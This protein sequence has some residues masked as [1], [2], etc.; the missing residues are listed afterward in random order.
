MLLHK[1]ALICDEYWIGSSINF[2][3]KFSL[4]FLVFLASHSCCCFS[5]D[6]V[7]FS[8]ADLEML[9]ICQGCPVRNMIRATWVNPIANQLVLFRFGK[10]E[11]IRRLVTS[12]FAGHWPKSISAIPPCQNIFLFDCFFSSLQRCHRNGIMLIKRFWRH[13]LFI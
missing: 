10:A 6:S 8:L 11:Q 9:L 12:V 4:V 13:K 3:G 2:L 7:T 5:S 1:I